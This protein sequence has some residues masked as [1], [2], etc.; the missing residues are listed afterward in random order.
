M[1]VKLERDRLLIKAETLGKQLQQI[2]EKF[3]GGQGPG[4]ENQG[5]P[6]EKELKRDATKK[7]GVKLT[8]IPKEDRLNPHTS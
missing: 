8:P 2:E 4:A 7:P 1:L 3:T 5:E 6:K